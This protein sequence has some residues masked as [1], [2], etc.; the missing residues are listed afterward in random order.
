MKSIIKLSEKEVTFRT[1]GKNCEQFSIGYIGIHKHVPTRL[2]TIPCLNNKVLLCK[3]NTAN[4]GVFLA[5]LDEIFHQCK[6]T[7]EQK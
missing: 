5:S 1:M 4:I 3:G 6:G 2:A 7:P